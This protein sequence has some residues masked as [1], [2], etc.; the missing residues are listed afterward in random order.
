MDGM[1][2]QVDQSFFHIY[3]IDI[4]ERFFL[5]LQYSAHIS[6]CDTRVEPVS[7]ISDGFFALLKEFQRRNKGSMPKNIIVF[8][9]GVAD[10]QFTEGQRTHQT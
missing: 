9:D 3:F 5:L 10:N 6:T 2:G 4:F 7:T 1:M 8:R